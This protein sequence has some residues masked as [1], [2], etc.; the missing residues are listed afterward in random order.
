[1]A[2]KS[3]IPGSRLQGVFSKKKKVDE[4]GVMTHDSQT[5]ESNNHEN[6][7]KDIQ[8]HES[9]LMNHEFETHDSRNM[10]HE[11]RTGGIDQKVLEWAIAKGRDDPRISGYSEFAMSMLRYLRKTT[12]EFSMSGAASDLLEEALR[13]KYP[14]LS[15][16]VKERME[17][18]NGQ[19]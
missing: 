19:T 18:A 16:A 7:I 14:D 15:K 12:P 9:G 17:K 8:S 10:S 2:D 6:E 13:Q 4:S 5:H 11:S 3:P 1:M